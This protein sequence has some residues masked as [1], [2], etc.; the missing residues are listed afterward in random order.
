MPV[1][2]EPRSKKKS[3]RVGGGEMKLAQVTGPGEA[4]FLV[5]ISSQSYPPG[6]RFYIVCVLSSGYFMTNEV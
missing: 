1:I 3:W 6:Y 5:A 2:T 4:S